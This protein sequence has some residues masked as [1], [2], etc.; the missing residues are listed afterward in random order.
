MRGDDRLVIARIITCG[1][2]LKLDDLKVVNTVCVILNTGS[3]SKRLAF[4]WVSVFGSMTYLFADWVLHCCFNFSSL[5]GTSLL[6][7]V[8]RIHNSHNMFCSDK[9]F[10]NIL[11][12]SNLRDT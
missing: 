1:C 4:L 8:Y 9:Q 3:L 5:I 10:F 7:N 2:N 6:S 11:D 12:S